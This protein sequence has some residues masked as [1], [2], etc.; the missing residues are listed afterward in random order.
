M[1]KLIIFFLNEIFS[2]NST[3][4]HE[5]FENKKLFSPTVHY[6][7]NFMDLIFAMIGFNLTF[8]FRYFT[9]LAT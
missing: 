3:D 5:V 7:R 1:F 9:S 8:H 4:V 6:M 2:W